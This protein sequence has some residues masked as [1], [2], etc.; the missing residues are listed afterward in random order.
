[1]K[2]QVVMLMFHKGLDSF[3]FN[4]QYMTLMKEYDNLYH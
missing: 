1:M 3:M 4:K 2:K